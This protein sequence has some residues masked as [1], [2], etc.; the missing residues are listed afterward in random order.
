MSHLL[1]KY[2]LEDDLDR[3]R[4]L[5][6]NAGNAQHA[7]KGHAG[8]A[9]YATSS[10]SVVGS[11]GGFG[12]SPKTVMKNRKVSGQIGNASGIKG[13]NSGLSRADINSR[14]HA[15]LTVLHRAA[16]S[17]SENAISFALALIEHPSIDLYIQDVESGWTALHR[18]LYAGNVTIARAII[19][20][21]RRD[22]NGPGGTTA[23]K[24]GSSVIKIKDRE[25][26]SPFDVYN[27]T[28][29]RRSLLRHQE[30]EQS[31]DEDEDES[32]VDEMATT[33]VAENLSING[34]EIFFWG[35]SKNHTLGFGDGDDRQYP[36]KITLK[37]PDHLLFRFYREYLES[38]QVPVDH[39]QMH[40]SKSVPKS[41]DELPSLILNRPIVIQDVTLS[42]LHSA[43]LT[44]DPEAN[45]Y[46]CGFGPGG[47][48]GTGDERT[49]FTFTCIEEGALTG[50]KVTTVALGQN[51]TLAVSSEGEIISWGNNAYGQLGYSLPRP[52]MKDEEPFCSTPRQIFG[53]LKR[54]TIIGVAASAIH[55]VA[56]TSTSLFTWGKNEGQLGLMD[57]DSRSLD[58]QT[59]PRKVAASLFK[60][61][62][63]MVSAINGAT[64]CLLANY[65]VCVF[66]NYGY[67]NVKFPLNEEFSNYHLRKSP[68]TTSDGNSNHISSIT[69]GGDT[70]AAIS[71]RGDLFTINV[72][73][74]ELNLTSTSTTNPSKIKGA[75]SQ[76]QRVWSLRKGNW[77]GIRS[78]GVSE[79]GSVIVCTQA[80]AVWRRIKRAKIKDTYTATGNFNRKDFKFERVPGLTKVAAVRS[81]PF[82]VYAAIRRDCDVTKNQIVV[83]EQNLW[84]DVAPLLSLRDLE[85]SAPPQGVECETPRF[86]TPALPRD[87]FDPVKR[88]VL[89]SPDIEADVASHLSGV[90]PESYD[91]ELC[92][93]TSEVRIPV[94]G[95]MLSSRSSIL[96]AAL[97]KF[98]LSGSFSMSDVF[99]LE[100]ADNQAMASPRSPVRIIFQ[101]LDFITIVN[102]AVYL[103]TDTIVDVWHFTRQCPKM[104]FRYRQVRVELMKTAGYL[105]MGKLESPVRLMTT[106]ERRMNTDMD[107]AIQDSTYFEDGDTIVELDGSEVLAHSSLLCHR[108]PFFQGLFNG[109]AGGQWLAGRRQEDSMAIRIDLKHIAPETF[110]LVLRYL[111]ADIGTELFDDVVS[112]DID[113]FSELVMDVMGVANELMLDRLSQICQ[114]VIGRFGKSSQFH[115]IKCPTY[116]MGEPFDGR[117]C[118][119][120]FLSQRGEPHY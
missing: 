108:C 76:P 87:L 15:G 26:N 63:L 111:Y 40:S 91:V 14:D 120:A 52:T 28:T 36:E 70:I 30:E 114:E 19:E 110:N 7:P 67:N 109:R 82:G 113:E 44:T 107:I 83:D 38:M 56:H 27:A 32:I 16:S 74:V 2:Y 29:A 25:G 77:D 79:N 9:G 47:R 95:F 93:T 116:R 5:L 62:I 33:E 106:P 10:S 49:R 90:D 35:S 34:D 1:W 50:K 102:L 71:S 23:S 98:R 84:R 104:A 66:T 42:K 103:Y 88:A 75:L 81:T 60:A 73:K 18:A 118:Y 41:L 119:P 57:S 48:L 54:E 115:R 45:L 96:R 6:A 11:P 21:D 92:T 112:P 59:V 39:P 24:A 61:P 89:G 3:F 69:A 65:T 12:T 8:A 97:S 4:R 72:R 53:P 64:I 37:R 85:P 51:H 101:G 100:D 58:M 17:T 68:F 13:A 20:R 105:K 55:S 99:T 43:I 22:P 94:H 78:V 86:W 31:K 117:I 46:I 80:G